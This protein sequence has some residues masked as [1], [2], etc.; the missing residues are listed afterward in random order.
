MFTKT[1]FVAKTKADR[2]ILENLPP[3]SATSGTQLWDTPPFAVI[4]VVLCGTVLKLSLQNFLCSQNQ[5]CTAFGILCHATL[6]GE[7]CSCNHSGF[8]S[9][10]RDRERIQ[11]CLEPLFYYV[12]VASHPRPRQWATQYC[13]SMHT[14]QCK[15]I[16]ATHQTSLLTVQY[17]HSTK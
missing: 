13:I 8:V 15:P 1:G 7:S 16:F 4:T 5:T 12:S 11:T 17:V 10:D 6:S 9:E 2:K 14:L 3:H